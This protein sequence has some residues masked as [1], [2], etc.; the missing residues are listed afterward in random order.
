[1]PEEIRTMYWQIL[2]LEFAV[3]ENLPYKNTF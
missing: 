2:D 3:E 1:M